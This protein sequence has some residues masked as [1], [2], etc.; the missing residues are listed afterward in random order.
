M[1]LLNRVCDLGMA[2]LFGSPPSRL[3]RF[4]AGYL[5]VAVRWWLVRRLLGAGLR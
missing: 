5:G 4:Q 3:I 1:V 2:R